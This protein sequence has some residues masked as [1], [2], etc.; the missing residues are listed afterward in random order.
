[1]D[2]LQFEKDSPYSVDLYFLETIAASPR[3]WGRRDASTRYG[4]QQQMLFLDYPWL[5][6][7]SNPDRGIL[8]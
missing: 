2:M 7:S 6:L 8:Y 1:M 4:L 5:R 3:Q